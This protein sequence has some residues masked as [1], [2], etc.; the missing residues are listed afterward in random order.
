MATKKAEEEKAVESTAEEATE[1]APKR[2]DE[3]VPGGRYIVGDKVV[4]A[5]GKELNDKGEVVE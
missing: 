4:N 2:I 3:T 5:E 1:D